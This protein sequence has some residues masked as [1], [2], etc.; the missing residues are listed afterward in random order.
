MHLNALFV[1]CKML[2][3][4]VRTITITHTCTQK[5]LTLIAKHIH[6]LYGS[7]L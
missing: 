2:F 4:A 1:K 3:W 6:L 5:H 7:I